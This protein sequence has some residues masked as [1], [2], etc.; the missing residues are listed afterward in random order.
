ML[1]K[2]YEILLMREIKR[3]P[4]HVVI[5]DSGNFDFEKFE[6]FVSWCRRFGIKEITLCLETDFQ[7]PVLEGFKVRI[8]K[9]GMI[10][11]FGNGDTTLNVISGYEGRD[12]I[13]NAIRKLA[14]LVVEGKI[15]PEEVDERMIERFMVIKSQPDI[16]IKAGNEIPSFLIWQSIYSELY[17][18]DIDWNSLRFVD[19][20]RILRE[21]QR[22][23]RRY[24]R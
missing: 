2:L 4:K 10:E 3:V 15:K 12:E 19:F 21:Y 16:I 20:L 1:L 14:D 9:N 24:G 6:K 17:F 11:V 23:E 22:R 18:A 7:F 13:V 5:V 8:V